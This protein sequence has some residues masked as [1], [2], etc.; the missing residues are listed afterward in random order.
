[1][2]ILARAG[3]DTTDPLGW[4]AAL[5]NYNPSAASPKKKHHLSIEHTPVGELAV[6]YLAACDSHMEGMLESL[7]KL[8]KEYFT[9]VEVIEGFVYMECVGIQLERHFSQRRS[10]ALTA[11]EKK[12]DITTALNVANRKRLNKLK[13]ELQEKLR[14]LGEVSHTVVKETKELHLES[15]TL[16]SELHELAMRRL[17]RARETSAERVVQILSKWAKETEAAAA[18]ELKALGEA[19]AT[20]ER[21]I[22]QEAALFYPPRSE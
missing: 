12:T 6:S 18:T 7:A 9:R 14:Q 20:L 4:S 15:K 8:L 11:F 22:G 10:S 19:M 16:K 2:A 21:A 3:V 17:T 5:P 13:E 1:L